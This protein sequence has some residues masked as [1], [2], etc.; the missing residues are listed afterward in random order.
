MLKKYKNTL[1]V[2]SLVALI[3]IVI[4]LLLWNKLPDQ[5]PFHWDI[6]GNVD[7]WASKSV[8]VFAMPAFMLVM[9]WVCVFASTADPKSANYNRK[10]FQL[11]LWIC[12]ILSIVLNTLVYC[13]A[14]GH[15]LPIETIIPM[16]M[17][18][19]FI[20]LGNL[21]PKMKQTY[22]MGIKL[23]WTLNNEENWNKTH[24]FAGKLWVAGGVI[25][26]ATAFLG[27]F[28]IFIGILAVMCIIPTIYSYRLFKKQTE[29]EKG[30]QE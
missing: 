8:A 5:V 1:I 6:N 27:S 21:L 2:T 30:D 7:N 3:P 17:G 18:V 24:R 15:S 10:S 25:T 20:V 13:T 28:W 26:M 23:P 29:N 22:T 12:P 9:Q 4:G 14:L 11:V 16:L 19:L